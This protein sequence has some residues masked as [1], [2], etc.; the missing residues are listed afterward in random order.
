MPACVAPG[1]APTASSGERRKRGLPPDFDVDFDKA[2]K[3]AEAAARRPPRA[4]APAPAPTRSVE[5]EAAAAPAPAPAN[6]DASLSDASTAARAPVRRTAPPSGLAVARHARINDLGLPSRN[7]AIAR[8]S[9][10]AATLTRAGMHGEAAAVNGIVLVA[11][12]LLD[13]IRE[14]EHSA[15]A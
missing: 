3:R 10:V 1:L 6:A 14:L 4:P 12:E 2:R 8:G 15:S 13:R 7:E 11:H 5:A 9:E